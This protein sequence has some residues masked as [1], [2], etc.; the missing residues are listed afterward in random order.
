MAISRR[1]SSLAARML[2]YTAA[3]DRCMTNAGIRSAL[4]SSQLPPLSPSSG[5][6]PLSLRSRRPLD[7]ECFELTP[8]PVSGPYSFPS[9]SGTHKLPVKALYNKCVVAVL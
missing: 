3:C 2:I 9:V 7:E 1:S 6:W 5:P 8:R 4:G